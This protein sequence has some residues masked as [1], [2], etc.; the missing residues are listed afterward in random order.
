MTFV[1]LMVPLLVAMGVGPL[2]PWKRGDLAAALGRLK[3]AFA[4]TAATALLVL[5]A[6]GVRSIGAACGLRWRLAVRRDADRTGGA[7]A[8]CSPSRCR[9]CCAARCACRAPPGA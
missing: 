1:P 4:L 7:G 9:A 8:A 5:V 2:L 6:S 3:L